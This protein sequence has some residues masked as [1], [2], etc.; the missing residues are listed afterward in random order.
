MN[1]TERPCCVCGATTSQRCGA[2]GKAGFSLFFC[3]N[4]HQ[5]LGW[6]AHKRVCGEKAKALHLSPAHLEGN[7]PRNR[8]PLHSHV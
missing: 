2:C 6:F 3:S 7:Q 4:E 5:K 1:E 8:V